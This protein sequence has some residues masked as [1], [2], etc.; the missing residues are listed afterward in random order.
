MKR[1]SLALAAVAIGL[2]AAGA[3]RAEGST[4]LAGQEV[5][6]SQAQR[7]VVVT[8]STRWVNV[9]HRDIVKL[10]SNGKDIAFDFSGVNNQT[11]DLASIAPAGMV[12]H[13]VKV[14]VG[15]NS[16]LN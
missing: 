6:V 10:E 9:T 1:S 7:T 4:D 13:P 3:A 11:V 14:Y 5:P 12:D 8:P 15:D 2:M 16:E